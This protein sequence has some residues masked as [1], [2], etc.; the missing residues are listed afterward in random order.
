MWEKTRSIAAVACLAISGRAL[1]QNQVGHA[2]ITGP[3][4]ETDRGS[5]SFRGLRVSIGETGP[6][7]RIMIRSSGDTPLTGLT[8]TTHGDFVI[9]AST[10]PQTLPPAGS[11]ESRC[12]VSV[13]FRPTSSGPRS[14]DLTIQAA[15]IQ[16]VAVPLIA[17]TPIVFPT[18]Q[19]GATAIQWVELPSPATAVSASVTGPF[20]IALQPN[21]TY[22]SINGVSFASSATTDG[23]CIGG[24]APCGVFLGVELLASAPVGQS[25]GTVTLSSGLTYSLAANVLGPGLL[26]TPTAIDEGGVPIGSTSDTNLISITNVLS[27]PITIGVPTVAGPFL[28]TSACGSSLAAGATCTV[29]TSFVPTTSG[30]AG[31]TVELP[32]GAGS[33]AVELTGAGVDNPANVRIAPATVN[34]M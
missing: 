14:D 27:S 6:S 21:Y 30:V 26:L 16:S 11:E 19:P 2:H 18:V 24:A 8:A 15:G 33:L 23:V 22:G 12:S 4:L 3:A 20:A 28:A 1:A 17:G 31:G 5:D 10:C 29:S 7:H 13:A 25:S 9:T 32:T 34:F